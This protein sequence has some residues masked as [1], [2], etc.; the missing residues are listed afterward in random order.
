MTG[1]FEYADRYVKESDWKDIALLKLCLCAIG[2]L[3][4]IN[5]AQRHKKKAMAA[6]ACVFGFTYVPLM[7]KF[8]KIILDGSKK[9]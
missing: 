7:K 8:I 6:A 3:I 4:G 2:V 5:I 1:L 9:E